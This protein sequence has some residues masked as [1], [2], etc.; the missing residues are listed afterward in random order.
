MKQ[1]TLTS[2]LL[3]LLF[4]VQAQVPVA[5]FKVTNYE[6]NGE[7][8]DEL[9]L[10]Y[11]VALS[12]YMCD[13]ET[14]CFANQWRKKGT[15]SYGGVYALKKQEIPETEENYRVEVIKFTW[16]YFNT[17]DSDRGEAAVT[18]IRI[19]VKNTI[20]FKAEILLLKTNEVLV[21]EGYQE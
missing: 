13:S 15:Q 18:L 1:I 7:N 8:F 11:D 2:L 12:F 19:F 21:M 3:M 9:A 10:E 20:R 16:K 5:T 4:A 6:I 17:Y 14:P